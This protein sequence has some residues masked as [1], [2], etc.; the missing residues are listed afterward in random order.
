[1][2]FKRKDNLLKELCKKALRTHEGLQLLAELKTQYVD[3]DLRGP[4][5]EGK[6]YQKELVQDLIFYTNM[7][8]EID[9]RAQERQNQLM[10]D[11]YDLEED[12]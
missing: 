5:M 12:I 6:V 8:D 9:R 11:E 10:L 1:M 2:F 3:C 7:S 4:E